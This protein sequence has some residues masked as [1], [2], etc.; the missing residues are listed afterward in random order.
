MRFHG[1]IGFTTSED[2][3]DG[4][5]IPTITERVYTGDVLANYY[6]RDSADK[7][8]DNIRSNNR[9]SIVCDDYA[10]RHHSYIKY[11]EL[12]GI[13]WEVTGV[14]PSPSPRMILTLGGPYGGTD[15]E[16][17]EDNG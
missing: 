4:V 12:Y 5:W 13:L 14:D 1:R 8:N 7:V 3:G 16:E 2:R 10:L 11:A 17:G 9:I 6:N 15:I